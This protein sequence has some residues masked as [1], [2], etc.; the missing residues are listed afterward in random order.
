MCVCVCY[1]DRILHGRKIVVRSY[2]RLIREQITQQWLQDN[3]TIRITSKWDCGIETRVACI[4]RM[5]YPPIKYWLSNLPRPLS[6]VRQVKL[7]KKTD[8]LTDWLT[9]VSRFL[10][11][12][13]IVLSVQ[14]QTAII[15]SRSGSTTFFRIWY[16]YMLLD[17][18][19]RSRNLWRTNNSGNEPFQTDPDSVLW[20][21]GSFV[22]LP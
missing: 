16:S 21:P 19:R 18:S 10:L 14:S 22:V 3:Q 4:C 1:K 17:F 15:I 20:N 9:E 8:W 11:I 2:G 13:H 5:F 7:E 6:L 12:V